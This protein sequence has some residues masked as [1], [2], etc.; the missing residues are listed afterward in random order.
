[1]RCVE[2]AIVVSNTLRDRDTCTRVLCW[3]VGQRQAVVSVSELFFVRTVREALSIER[4]AEV[5]ALCTYKMNVCCYTGNCKAA[6]DLDVS[7]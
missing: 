4:E 7:R 1:M 6:L 5:E 2:F 3:R